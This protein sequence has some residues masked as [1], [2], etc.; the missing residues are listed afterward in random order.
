MVR[1]SRVVSCQFCRARKLRCNRQFPCS[2]CTTRGVP[3]PSVRHRAV[4]AENGVAAVT[5]DDNVLMR[6][7]SRLQRLEEMLASSNKD[8]PPSSD[9]YE[10]P[11]V[12]DSNDSFACHYRL[13]QDLQNLTQDALSINQS[14]YRMQRIVSFLLFPRRACKS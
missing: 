5:N 7:Q 10:A 12:K 6:L 9:L 14:C 3:C 8:S 1:Q 13:P 11:R 2:N 4:Q